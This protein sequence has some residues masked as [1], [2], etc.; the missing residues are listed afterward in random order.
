M[1]MEKE[2]K[3]IFKDE[4]GGREESTEAVNETNANQG[5][6]VYEFKS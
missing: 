2:V 5:T 1:M 3:M 4:R 6:N